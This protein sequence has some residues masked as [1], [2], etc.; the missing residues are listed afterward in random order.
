MPTQSKVRLRAKM[1]IDAPND[2]AWRTDTELALLDAATVLDM[3]FH[4]YLESYAWE[5]CHPSPKRRG[6]AIDT[7]E[8]RHIGNCVYYNIDKFR[9]EAELG[10]MLGDRL[11]WEKGYGTTA[12]KA[13]I[14][15]I[16]QRTKLTRLYLKTLESNKRAQRCFMK[17]GL[18]AYGRRSKND[19][20]FILM[21]IN[22]DAWLASLAAEGGQPVYKM[23][24]R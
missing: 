24:G 19:Y 7:T 6:F 11:Y 21:E 12:M 22:R 4:T 16:F 3:D 9:G 17:C 10:I 18:K 14:R 15:H 23:A 2:Y 5:L 1:L 20:D 13:L 8:G